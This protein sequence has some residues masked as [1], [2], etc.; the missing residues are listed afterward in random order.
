MVQEPWLKGR[1]WHPAGHV[2]AENHDHD[3]WKI[4]NNK[5]NVVF[6][7]KQKATK[8]AA[9][10]NAPEREASSKNPKT[11]KSEKILAL[12]KIF[13]SALTTNFHLSDAE[14][15]VLVDDILRVADSIKDA[16]KE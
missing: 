8:S 2:N 9:K 11:N 5:R 14:A 1:Q 16:S 13:V 6:K 12:W 10:R 4:K 15:Q 7:D 3:A